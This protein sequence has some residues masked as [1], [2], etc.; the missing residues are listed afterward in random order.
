MLGVSMYN[1]EKAILQIN[2][3]LLFVLTYMKIKHVNYINFTTSVFL[4]Y[5]IFRIGLVMRATREM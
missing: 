2:F 4:F 3:L 1:F 5:C